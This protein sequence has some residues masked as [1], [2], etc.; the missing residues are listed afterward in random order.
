MRFDLTQPLPEKIEFAGRTWTLHLS[1]DIVLRVFALYKD[2]V[3]YAGEKQELALTLLVKEKNP[4]WAI[5]EHIFEEY[6]SVTKKAD[7]KGL[8]CFDFLQDGAYLYSSF[9]AD[10][11]I[12]LTQERGKL[13]WWKFVALFQGLSEGTKMR[14][15]MRIRR[16]E[17]PELN[18]HNAKY[19]ENLMELKQYYALEITQEEREQNLRSGFER[20]AQALRARALS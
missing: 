11:G 13:H 2:D 10:Y 8:K 7:T 1:F 3:L 4:P 9:L 19:I 6:I 5:L 20:L 12:D 16:E 17:I 14:E 15:V 18:Q